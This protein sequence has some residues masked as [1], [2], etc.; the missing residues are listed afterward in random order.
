VSPPLLA[1]NKRLYFNQPYLSLQYNI[2]FDFPGRKWIHL[3]P[4]LSHNRKSDISEKDMAFQC[5]LPLPQKVIQVKGYNTSEQRKFLLYHTAKHTAGY[6][7]CVLE[8]HSTKAQSDTIGA[9]CSGCLF[10]VF[11]YLCIMVKRKTRIMKKYCLF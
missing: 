5:S 9:F 2:L 4:V 3:R 10:F 7:I 1:T 6:T 11:A 8:N